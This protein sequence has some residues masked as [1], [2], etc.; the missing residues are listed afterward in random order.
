MDQSTHEHVL[1][2]CLYRSWGDKVVEWLR[3]EL[4]ASD[5]ILQILQPGY[6]INPAACLVSIATT[7]LVM[8]GVKESKV[9]SAYHVL[10]LLSLQFYSTVL[11]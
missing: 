1:C 6:G 10:F 7:A 8:A 4:N 11:I 9:S 5:T 2:S 3:V